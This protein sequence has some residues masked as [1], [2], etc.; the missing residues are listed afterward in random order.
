MITHLYELTTGWYNSEGC[1]KIAA[2]LHYKKL[3]HKPAVDIDDLSIDDQ[4]F[5]MNVWDTFVSLCDYQWSEVN[6]QLDVIISKRWNKAAADIPS[7]LNKEDYYGTWLQ[8]EYFIIIQQHCSCVIQGKYFKH[9]S[10]F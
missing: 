10:I 8:K 7:F 3:K 6:R 1:S 5:A 4:E 2:Y 9:C